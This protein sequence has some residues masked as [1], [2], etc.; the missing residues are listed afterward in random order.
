MK[1]IIVILLFSVMS[2]SYA[3]IETAIFAGGCFWCMQSDFDKLPGVV[4]T[5]VGYDGG[6]LKNP[7]YPVVSAGKTQYVESVKVEF[8]TKKTSY[9]K[10]LDYYWRHIDPTVKDKQFCDVGKQYRTVIFTLTKEQAKLAKAS[11][12]KLYQSFKIINTE[13]TPSTRFY[14]AEDYHQRYYKK[15]PSLYEY[16]RAQCGRDARVKKIWGSKG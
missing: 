6:H 14:S 13:I 1:K 5:T 9:Q 10:V 12:K 4:K 8:D 7:T 2:I 11:K 3:K 15:N 16:Y